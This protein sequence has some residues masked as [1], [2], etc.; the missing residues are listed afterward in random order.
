MYWDE[1]HTE[2]PPAD[3][4]SKV[5]HITTAF[6][7]STV[8]NTGSSA[9]PFESVQSI[10][11]TFGSDKKVTIAIGGWGD[12]SGFSTGAQG[13][14]TRQTYAKN[15]AQMLQDTGADG[16]DIDWEYPG[17]NGDDYKQVPNSQKKDEIEEY[18]LFLQAIREAIGPDK[19]LSIA[20]PG[21]KRDMIAFTQETGPKIW[22]SVDMVNIMAYD[23]MN[24]RDNQTKHASSIEGA[25]ASV[26]NYLDIGMPAE[27][28]N[29]GFPFYAKWF[30]TAKDCGSQPLG[31]PVVPLENAQGEDTGKSGSVTFE[32]NPV[33]PL[34]ADVAASWQRAQSGAQYDA[35]AGGEYFFDSQSNIFWTWDTEDIME[36]KFSEIVDPLKVGGV[37]AWSLGEDSA[38]WKHIAAISS[39]L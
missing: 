18:P 22:P 1:W 8:F 23:L 10:K 4:L 39:Q 3:V 21:L 12:T 13:D 20:V 35:Q 15:V 33:D 31:C 7:K 14:S 16:V 30:T 37:M 6:A 2:Q 19:L 26:Q 25:K 32:A 38:G 11:S 29:L 36:K 24:R 9:Q 34:P 17:G 5:T 28:A 27:K